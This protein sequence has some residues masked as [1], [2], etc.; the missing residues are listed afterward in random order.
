LGDL[1]CT[2]P[3]DFGCSCARQIYTEHSNEGR[4]RSRDVILF[5]RSEPGEELRFGATKIAERAVLR[6]P[7]TGKGL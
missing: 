3:F 7:L 6:N 2:L 5:S 1:G 4:R